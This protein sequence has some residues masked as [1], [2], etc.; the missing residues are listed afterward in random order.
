MKRHE[1]E[2]I[3]ETM[4]VLATETKQ[5]NAE[6]VSACRHYLKSGIASLNRRANHCHK[7]N[8]RRMEAATV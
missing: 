4:E 7:L 1:L 3:L 8:Q 5:Q 6:T 2:L